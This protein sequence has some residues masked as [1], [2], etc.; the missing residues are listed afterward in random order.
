MRTIGVQ[1]NLSKSVVSK[2]IFEFAKRI[3]HREYD[4]S[5]ISFKEMDVAS[6]NIDAAVLL[7]K[8]FNP[9]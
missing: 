3:C 2:E 6:K 5:P 8:K 1:I 7:F 9:D 4:L